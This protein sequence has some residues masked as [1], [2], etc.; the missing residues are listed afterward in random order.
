MSVKT[1]QAHT[2]SRSL[3]GFR[4]GLDIAAG[5]H[6]MFRLALPHKELGVVIDVEAQQCQS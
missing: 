3:P 1:G 2:A 4:A 5:Q 6:L